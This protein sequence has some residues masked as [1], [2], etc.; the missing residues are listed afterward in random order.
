MRDV[1][2]PLGLLV[3]RRVD[4]E[5]VRRIAGLHATGADERVRVARLGADD[6]QI[7]LEGDPPRD[8]VARVCIPE[9]VCA[10]RVEHRRKVRRHRRAFSP[11]RRHPV[12]VQLDEACDRE[13][14]G[15]RERERG[16]S[17]CREDG[18]REQRKHGQ[19][20]RQVARLRLQPRV[21]RDEVEDREHGD[22]Q[23]Q[24]LEPRWAAYA[25]PDEAG[26]QPGV[27][28]VADDRPAEPLERPR[29]PKSESFRQRRDD[30]IVDVGRPAAF[31]SARV[32]GV[33]V[34][35]EVPDEPR[36]CA[37]DECGRYKGG[38]AQHVAP[39]VGEPAE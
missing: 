34:V 35:A 11:E 1:P 27:E 4:A 9:V 33:P 23:Q 3:V 38:A 18:G 13:C 16:T 5:I 26:R 37:D 29:E 6:S 32:Q 14:A 2:V 30:E 19:H 28:Q 8:P 15:E 21:R 17:A 25:E 12:A 7:R 39:G 36:E 22:D 31:V 24:R 10:Q 20:E